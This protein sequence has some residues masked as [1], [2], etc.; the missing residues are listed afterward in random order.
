MVGEE[1]GWVALDGAT[2]TLLILEMIVI[3]G[4]PGFLLSLA[5]FPKRD[6]MPMSERMALSFGLGL[7]VPFLIQILNIS[8]G[9]NVN[10]VT[11]ALITVVLMVIG[12]FGFMGRGGN[13][14]LLE[15]NREKT[16]V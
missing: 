12:I 1:F 5:V 6:A 4:L 16:K 15:W 13:L 11:S 14:N 7:S 9:M 3:I 2:I 10:F 8:L